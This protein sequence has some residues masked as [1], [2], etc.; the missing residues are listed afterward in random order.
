MKELVVTIGVLTYNSSKYVLET[1]E[2]IKAQTYPNLILQIS[3]DCSTDNTIELCKNWIN[4]NKERFIKT[5]IIVP[6]HNTGVSAN[7][8]RDWDACE[9][10]W[11]KEVAGDDIL[12]PNC[13]EDNLK[14]IS[15]K[16]DAIIVFSRPRLFG[17]GKKECEKYMK[18]FD[19]SIFNLNSEQQYER[20]KYKN[21]LPASTAFYNMAKIRDIGLRHDERIPFLEDKPKW[22]NA[23]KRGI[24]F[25]YLEKETV[26]YRIHKDSLSSAEIRSPRFYESLQL[27]YYYYVFQPLFEQNPEQAIRDAVSKELLLYQRYLNTKRERDSFFESAVIKF[28]RKIKI[29]FFR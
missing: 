12:L 1:L 14:Y 19:F 27:C 25:H 15:E 24:R 4:K 18:K 29:I 11:L 13:I 21:C 22:I 5:T 2:S 28:L 9:T 17:V 10:E 8:N 16:P 7:A 23:L 3:D 26:G 20:I 6:E